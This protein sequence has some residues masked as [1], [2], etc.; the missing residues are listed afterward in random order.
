M[1]RARSARGFSLVELMIALV[2]ALIVSGAVLSFFLSSMKSN[3]EYVQSTRLTQ[4][5]RNT[6]D[7]MTRD[8]QRA[9]YDEDALTYLASGSSTPFTP[10]KL[11]LAN[12]CIVYS[13]DKAGGTPGTLDLGNGE[14]HAIRLVSATNQEGKT[15]GPVDYATSFGTTRPSCTAA[16]ATYTSYPPACNGTTGWCAL[17]DPAILDITGLGFTDNRSNV[18]VSP[19]QVQLRKI[20][21]DLQ[22]RIAGTTVTPRNIVASVRVRSDCYNATLSNCSLSP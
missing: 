21:I 6:M 9:G 16:G 1:T 7:L 14:I 18:G 11:D 3:G 15:L 19:N 8:L 10:I 12:N 20:G 17:S 13:Y 2:A 5:L 4:E 22:G